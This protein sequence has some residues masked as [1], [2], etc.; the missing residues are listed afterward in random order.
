MMQ[1][2]AI[3][4]LLTSSLLIAGMLLYA[5]WYGVKILRSWDLHSGSELQ[6]QLERR[7]YLIS[8]ILGY[9]L[10]FQ[11]LSLF[12]FIFTADSLHSQFTG[13]M[14]AAGSLNAN[15]F[16]YPTFFLK[17]ATCILAGVWLIINHVDTRGYDYPLIRLKYGILVAILAPLVLIEAFLQ[18]KY[19]QGL[20]ADVITSCCGSLFSVDRRSIGGDIAALPAGPME[21]VFYSAVAATFVSGIIFC[22]KGRGGYFFSVASSL[23]FIISTLSLVSFVCLYIYELPSHHCPFC[24]LQKEYGYVGYVLYVSLFCGGVAGLGTGA[25]MPFRNHVSLSRIIPAVQHKLSLFALASYLLYCLIVSY[26]LI[27]SS[28]RLFP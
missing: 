12:L 8:S 20:H 2:P 27:F 26:Y 1:H 23:M 18:F 9:V 4:A 25:L 19:F 13:A 7:T 16:G 6:L 22:L 11:V 3:Q 17:I 10:A 21:W 5:A 24:I 28:L 14:C 15:G